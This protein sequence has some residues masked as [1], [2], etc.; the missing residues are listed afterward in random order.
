MS[1]M[2]LQVQISWVHLKRHPK[3]LGVQKSTQQD[4]VPVQLRLHQIN[5]VAVPEFLL[6][7]L[8]HTNTPHWNGGCISSVSIKSGHNSHVSIQQQPN[9][10]YLGRTEKSILITRICSIEKRE[11]LHQ[12]TSWIVSIKRSLKYL[13][14]HW[15]THPVRSYTLQFKYCHWIR[16]NGPSQALSQLSLQAFDL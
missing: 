4:N 15:D 1:R 16:M 6:L 7:L 8:H 2:L 3:L 5:S 14:L 9:A 12:I 10:S 13:E 11:L